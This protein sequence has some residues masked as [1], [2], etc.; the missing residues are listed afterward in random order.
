MA[1]F[2]LW[3]RHGRA[4]CMRRWMQVALFAS[5]FV[6]WVRL[7]AMS[8]SLRVGGGDGDDGDEAVAD[9]VVPLEAVG[10]GEQP[11]TLEALLENPQNDHFYEKPQGDHYYTVCNGLAD[12]ML[13]HAAHI[14]LAILRKR[15]VMI[16]DSLVLD[17]A[18]TTPGG[19]VSRNAVPTTQNSVPLV[20]VFDT[21]VLLEK[22]ANF[23]IEARIVHYDVRD[24]DRLECS[25]VTA[26]KYAEPDVVKELL[27]AM[28]PSKGML[29]LLDRTMSAMIALLPKRMGEFAQSEHVLNTNTTASPINGAVCLHHRDGLDWHRH[30]DLWERQS[31]ANVNCRRQEPISELVRERISHLK[32]AWVFYAGDHEIPADL[33]VFDVPVISRKQVSISHSGLM[34]QLIEKKFES[35]PRGVGAVLDYLLCSQMPVFIGNSA[36]T[37][38]AS[39]ILLRDTVASWYNSFGVPLGALLKAYT[40]PF[41]YTYTEESSPGG[42]MLLK[43]SV[44][45]VRRSM[46]AAQI[47][48]LYHGKGDGEFRDWLVQHGVFLHEH[49]PKWRGHIERMRL[50]GNRLASHLYASSGNY[51]GTWQRIDIPEFLSVEYCILLDSDAFVVRRFTIDDLGTSIPKALAFSSELDEGDGKPSNAGVALMNVPHLRKSRPK[52]LEFIL[53]H[54]HPDF[55]RGPS[56]Q[57]AY[58]E[59][60]D[61]DV[62]FL[63]TRFNM[64]PY[65]WDRE[66]WENRFIIHYHG[67]KPHEHIEYWFSGT[68]EPLKCYLLFRFQGS[69]YQCD[70]LVAFAKAAAFDGP[71]LI[72]QYCE[73][74]LRS[75]SDLCIDLLNLMANHEVPGQSCTDYCEQV[76][77]QKGLSPLDFPHIK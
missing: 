26:L 61:E 71:D 14:A 25:Y 23:G 3:A 5:S 33:K 58:L 36:S 55:R 17:S 28:V 46:P 19:G 52:F 20:A 34:D 2:A 45:S 37:W 76:L 11:A 38:S 1:G 13:G 7:T 68:C 57:G 32:N 39:Q 77:T 65:Y 42:K 29:A 27:K 70:S 15:P 74:S 24:H 22:I 30:C 50:N 72:K 16:P 54:T 51:L 6:V 73:M 47:H 40:I 4:L 56:D 41:V 75:H 48:I 18:F 53:N 69:P 63:S 66:N 31:K 44:L 43:V 59:F 67:L 35:M 10:V 9:D 8:S 49:Q 60:Y 64:K 12:Q 62:R 21:G